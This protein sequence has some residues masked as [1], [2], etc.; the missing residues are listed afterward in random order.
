MMRTTLLVGT[1]AFLGAAAI[2]FAASSSLRPGQHQ[3]VDCQGVALVITSI[4]ANTAT[5]RCLSRL[6]ES[7]RVGATAPLSRDRRVTL[8]SF[9]LPV[10]SPVHKPG[11]GKAFALADVTLCAGAARWDVAPYYF[12]LQLTDFTR[13]GHS[14]WTAREP[15]LPYTTLLPRD[16]VRGFVP[17]EVTAG[18]P[19]LALQVE[20]MG[21]VRRWRLR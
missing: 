13:Y 12:Q 1:L 21:V 10:S 19:A 11:P 9:A 17:F 16:C 5:A 18:V 2:A 7:Y 14:F 6:P 20:D 3:D 15:D 8:N 4:D